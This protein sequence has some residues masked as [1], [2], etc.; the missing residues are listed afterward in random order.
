MK[1]SLSIIL[2]ALA[3]IATLT[4]CKPEEKVFTIAYAP[5][6]STTESADSRYGLAQDLEKV[7][8]MKVKEIQASDYNAIIEGLRTGQIDIAYA[9]PQAVALGI[10]RAK[11]TPIVMKAPEGK[12]ELAFYKSVII[13]SADKSDINSIKD[14]KGKSMA[15]V[16]PASTSG[17][18]IPSSDIMAAFPDEDLNL[19]KLRTNGQFFSAVSFSGKH[20]AGLMAVL[21]KDVDLAPI[22]NQILASEIA[23]GRAKESDIKV[24][25][26]SAPIPAEAII[27]GKHLDD[28]TKAKLVE[29]FTKYDNETYFTE[30]IKKP[31]ARFVECTNETYQPIIELNNNLNEQ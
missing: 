29:F 24:I 10:E 2:G 14:I 18:L 28:E 12:K 13:T 27:A 16:D 3:A 25:H 21:K 23:H 11:C 22:S 6:E 9:G 1:K 17:S 20:Q 5:N 26:E 31:G 30:V 15:F 4:S 7:L 19:D 8:G